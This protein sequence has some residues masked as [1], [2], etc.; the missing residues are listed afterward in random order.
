MDFE[1][2][3]D[4]LGGRNTAGMARCPGHPDRRA[5]L[6]V[7]EGEDGRT[8]LH[9]KAGCPLDVILAAAGL[10]AAD[11]FAKRNGDRPADPIV[12]VYD[13]VD[14]TGAVLFQVVRYQSKKFLQRRPDGAG[15]WI[16][17]LKDVRRVLYRLPAVLEAVATDG[18]VVYVVEGEKDV[19]A[20]E[21]AGVVATCN[22]GGAGKWRKDYTAALAGAF[23][24]VIVADRDEPGRAHA[25]QVAASL[26]GHV[27]DLVV[28]EPVDGKDAADHLAAGHTVE[29]F[30]EVALY[31]PGNR[32]TVQHPSPEPVLDPPDLA[33]DLRILDRFAAAVVLRGVVGERA[34]A[35]LLY[36]VLTSRLLD[37][38]VSVVVKGH[39]ASGKSFTTETVLAFFPPSAYLAKTAMSQRALIYM[40]DDF[41]HRTLVLFEAVALREG[42]EDDM[43]AY[44][45]RSLLSE[46]R[47]EYQVTV[48]DKDGGGFTTKNI[49]KQGPTN[50]ILTT[51]KTRIHAENE[52]RVLSLA[53]DDTR[54]QTAR[55]FRALADETRRHVDLD[56][57]RALQSWLANTEHRVTIPYARSLV[58]A[59]P[60]VA[61]R[62]RR[63]VGALLALI[64]SHAILHQLN[65][66]S[67]G[68]GRVVA[69]LDDYAVV[70]ELVHD[71]LAEGVGATVSS[72]V[73]ATVDVLATLEGAHTN[74]V[75]VTLLAA[76]LDLDKSTVSRRL[77][78][79]R[80]GGYA[81]NLEESRG[82]PAR[83]K[84]GDPLP[85]RCELLPTVADLE[86]LVDLD[87][88]TVACGSAGERE[89]GP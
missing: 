86:V 30:V 70:R 10:N 46:G 18:E 87:C 14:E 23:R 39:S 66:D 74:G 47:I 49:V 83:W 82:K 72:E 21:R 25:A 79:A 68:D 33:R 80:D 78:K 62:L 9:C 11:L 20:L 29:A 61:V 50:L 71:L 63:D 15:G 76:A 37:Q 7:T 32:A 4:R 1:E 40:P 44:L 5:S 27:A 12:D 54:E 43:T 42:V 73:R 77:R 45:V 56:E 88:C 67:D 51:T 64:R 34:T 60:P 2:I 3:V 36:L 65:R 35:Q 24:V 31:P 57:W 53:T 13:Y 28:V 16:W 75:T 38:Q 19:Q 8:L 48:R 55:V 41:A 81:V 52:T 85:D 89:N 84:T 26:D 17:N 59:I 69:T 22:P 6:S 58:E